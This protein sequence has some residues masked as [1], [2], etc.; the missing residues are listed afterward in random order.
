MR[1]RLSKFKNSG[2]SYSYPNNS[3]L[4]VGLQDNLYELVEMSSSRNIFMEAII[5]VL[6]DVIMVLKVSMDDYDSQ[7]EYETAI[8]GTSINVMKENSV[9][10]GIPTEIVD[11][12][13]TDSLTKIIQK[14]MNENKPDAFSVLDSETIT[15]NKRILDEN[16]VEVLGAATEVEPK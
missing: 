1:T 6:Q 5:K 11:L 13:D 2:F 15:E 9:E 14:I 16:V 12:L 4:V 3:I 8:I 7:E 10:F